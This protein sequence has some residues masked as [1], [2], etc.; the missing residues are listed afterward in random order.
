ML[1]S[2]KRKTVLCERLEGEVVKLFKGRVLP[3]H[4]GASAAYAALMSQARANG[5]IIGMA[6]GQIA[7]I[8]K[9]QSMKVATRDTRPYVAAGIEVI[10]PWD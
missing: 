4:L 9:S 1:P 3:Y 2:G 6:D 8:A 7:A 10:N 5:L